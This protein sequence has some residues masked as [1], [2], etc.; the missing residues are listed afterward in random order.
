MTISRRWSY[1][2]CNAILLA[3]DIHVADVVE[4]MYCYK[5]I[6]INTFN[7]R[8]YNIMTAIQNFIEETGLN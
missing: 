1:Q 3:C 5:L 6:V 4:K 7:I 2:D 8:S